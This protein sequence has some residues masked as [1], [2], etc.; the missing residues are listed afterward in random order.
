[1]TKIYENIIVGDGPI[2]RILQFNNLKSGKD[3]L[4][5]DA[6]EGLILLRTAI[7]VES[8]INYVGQS[9]SPSLNPAASQFFWAGGCQGWPAE[10]M[11]SA[12]VDTLPL[13]ELENQFYTS[14]SQVAKLLGIKNFDFKKDLP[15]LSTTKNWLSRNSEMKRI[16]AKILS[17]PKL[18]KIKTFNDKFHDRTLTNVII[19]KIIPTENHIVLKGFH[20][21]EMQEME[22]R[23][24]KLD[25]AAGTIENTR[26]L[27]NSKSELK[28]Q[29]T[30]LLGKNLSD[31]LSLKYSVYATSEL[32]KVIR[33]FSRPKTIDGLRIWPRL[34]ISNYDPTSHVRSF[35][36][37]DQFKFD[38]DGLPLV[39]RILRRLGQ[40]RFYFGRNQNGKF[41]LNLFIE[42]LNETSNEIL[43][44]GQTTKGI[45]NIKI[46]FNLNEQEFH[47]VKIIGKA[48]EDSL[49]KD[50]PSIRRESEKIDLSQIYAGTHPSGTYRMSRAPI[51]G[52]VNNRSQL[53]EDFRIKV[54]GSG[55]FPRASATH[56]T[57]PSIALSIIE[58]LT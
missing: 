19:T 44:T 2:G 24:L 36:H 35:A 22:F 17:D 49:K 40:E 8:N 20:C 53:W 34:K 55:V 50:F 46:R 51:S 13:S 29:N 31:H 3:S 57:F 39:Y 11:N 30:N 38:L 43:L 28:I 21:I 5:L 32:K 15:S 48:Y 54:H 1:M 37:I 16:Y 42:K 9:M 12:D 10:D 52:I 27:L 4:I 25:L 14:Q 47:G 33:I 7:S 41:D 23:C 56:P 26:L 6:G 45:P 18:E 58:D